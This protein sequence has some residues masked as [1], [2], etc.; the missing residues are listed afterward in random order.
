ME[1]RADVNPK[2]LEE[3]PLVYTAAGLPKG[4]AIAHRCTWQPAA[5]SPAPEAL[6]S[7]TPVNGPERGMIL[8]VP[9]APRFPIASY[10]VLGWWRG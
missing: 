9:T 8:Q 7:Q 3:L 2:D 5:S 1:A 10:G 4:I 6:R